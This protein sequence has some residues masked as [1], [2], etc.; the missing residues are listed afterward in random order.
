MAHTL[1][2][3]AIGLA[4]SL[5]VREL[6]GVPEAC[7]S[8]G[9]PNLQPEQ[10]ENTA[11]P[12]VLWER[13]HCPDCGWTGRPV[14]ILDIESGRPIITRE[15][16]ESDDH[17]IM[18]VPLRTIRRPGDPPIEPLKDAETGPPEPA[19][20]FA[21]GSNMAT[22]RLRGRILSAKPLGVATLRGH[23]LRFHKRSKDKSAKCNAFA[24]ADDDSAVIGVL[25]SFDPAER[26]K[27][28]AA[29]GAGKGYDARVVTV[30]NDKGRRRKVLT[31][32]AAQDA[33]DDSLK[34]YS[35]YKDHVLAGGKEHNLPTDYI[36]QCIEGVEAVEDPDSARD[37]KERATLANSEG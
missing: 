10:G 35:W 25:F 12:G 16:E 32:L 28:D 9:S 23:A 14:P 13:P 19:E 36:A 11:A 37:K 6:R 29:E 3:H 34:P 2:Q 5:I 33:I 18:T 22:A 21:Y 26:G 1:I 8:C 20:Y 4:T 7:P 24:T 15:G 17:S 30:I 27:L 31:Y